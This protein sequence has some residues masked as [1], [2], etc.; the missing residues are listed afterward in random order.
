MARG[1]IDRAAL[2]ALARKRAR[3]R[4]P[5]PR[6]YVEAYPRLTIVDARKAAA[7]GDNI[8]LWE[9][10]GA[11]AAVARFR[12]HASEALHLSY[13][14]EP[15]HGPSA[16]G[17]IMLAIVYVGSSDDNHR[18]LVRCPRCQMSRSA[19]VLRDG[20][21][22]CRRCH[23][24]GYRSA[25]VGTAVRRAEKLARL[26]EELAVLERGFYPDRVCAAKRAAVE[27]ARAIVGHGPLMVAHERFAYQLATRF[28][29]G[30][31]GEEAGRLIYDLL[32][33]TP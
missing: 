1:M 13:H 3:W 33:L 20:A 6:S 17:A 32:P 21:W 9:W 11:I 12:W 23:G 7:R 2:A 30:A 14:H 19:V 29:H 24:L 18:A 26:E 16:E 15:E 22:A 28:T 4:E 5:E 10:H 27:R 25:L 8:A 31:D